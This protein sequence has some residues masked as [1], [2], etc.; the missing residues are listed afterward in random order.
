MEKKSNSY[1]VVVAVVLFVALILGNYFQYQLSPLAPRLM[2]AMGLTP[3]QFSS[4]FSAPMIPPI[5]LGIVAGMLSDKYGV[6]KVASIGL[7]ITAVGLCFR[8]FAGNYGT[9][10]ASMILGGV[11]VAF[12]NANMSKI[13]GGWFPPEKVGTIVGLTMV[14]STIGMTL[15][16]A[17]TALLPS[18]KMAFWISG[19]ASIAVLV[20]WLLFM[21]DGAQ[22]QK[23]PGAEESLL[24]SIKVVLRNK[25]IWL[26]GL[27]LMCI[28]GC[29]V[30]LASFLPTALQSR[31][32][33]E[34][35]SGVLASVITIGSLAGTF[36]GPTIISKASRMKPMLLIFALLTAVGAAFGWSLPVAF[37]IILL[38]LAGFGMGALIPVFMSFPVMLPEIGPMYA[39]SAGGVITT[40]E[41]LGAVI[42][43][44]YVITPVAGQNFSLYF[45][46]TGAVMVVMAVIALLLPE[47]N[48]K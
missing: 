13:I 11:G 1:G 7:V 36:V 34:S 47:L 15:G 20:I 44:T 27:C 2:E 22:S 4:I 5:F 3:G 40:L 19:I 38:A 23:E 12:L 28:L 16:T 14:G 42:L 18:I 43:P 10:F 45:M 31:G 21:K 8:P 24:D 41:L 39:G 32:I 29:N 9:L 37:A 30:A 25:N 26:V 6:K 48:K 35:T 33:N 17:T 46:I